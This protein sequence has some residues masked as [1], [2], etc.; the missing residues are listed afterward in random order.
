MNKKNAMIASVI[1][2]VMLLALV[3]MV[4]GN[5]TKQAQEFVKPI[6]E[7]AKYQIGQVKDITDNNNLLWSLVD[8]TWK[9]PDK[10]KA[11]VKRLADSQK[12]PRCGGKACTGDDARLKT[13]SVSNAQER[14]I[15]VGWGSGRGGYKYWFKVFYDAKDKFVT[16]DVNDLLGKSTPDAGEEAEGEEAASE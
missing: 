3:F 16:I 5:A 14:S 13:S 9:S 7:K 6:Q 2:N 15:T 12:L 11:F 8:S 10:S 4:K 1:L